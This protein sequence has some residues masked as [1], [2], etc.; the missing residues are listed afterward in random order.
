MYTGTFL[1]KQIRIVV[2]SNIGRR[3]F[4]GSQVV[5]LSPIRII[6]WGMLLY[7]ELLFFIIQWRYATLYLLRSFVI[8]FTLVGLC[9]PMYDNTNVPL[10]LFRFD[11]TIFYLVANSPQ[12]PNPFPNCRFTMSFWKPRLILQN[13][14]LTR[15]PIYWYIKT[16][17]VVYHVSGDL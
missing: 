1:N 8:R 12:P 16:V 3:L 14:V 17:W 5:G 7:D 13:I 11:T 15:L 4:L 2:V 9:F 10:D 6:S